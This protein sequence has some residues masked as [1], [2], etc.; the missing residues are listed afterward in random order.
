MEKI[1]ERIDINNDTS[2]SG[3]K[4]TLEEEADLIVDRFVTSY[5]KYKKGQLKTIPGNIA[6]SQIKKELNI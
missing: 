6:L 4:L 3:A 5:E 2:C 1:K